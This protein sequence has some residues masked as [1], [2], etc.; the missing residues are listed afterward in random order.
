MKKTIR[1]L[2]CLTLVLTMVMA[3]GITAFAAQDSNSHLN[4]S[5]VNLTDTGTVVLTKY[6]E[7]LG[8]TADY[9][10]PEE[11]YTVTIAKK[12]FE[13]TPSYVTMDNMP[14]I[15]SGSLTFEDDATT[16]AET[17]STDGRLY[18]KV[19]ATLPIPAYQY[20][21][22]YWYTVTENVPTNP[23]AGVTYDAAK[24]YLHVQVIKKDGTQV[25]SADNLI[26]LVTLH[27]QSDED[28]TTWNASKTDG[29]TNKYGSGKLMINKTVQGNQG[30]QNKK[31]EVN[32]T[33]NAP[34]GET[35][36]SIITYTY[37]DEDNNV[38]EEQIEAGWADSKEIAVLVS[39]GETATF[40]NIPYGVTYKVI[41]TDFS[42][43]GYV[44]PTYTL[45]KVSGE[46]AGDV[47]HGTATSTWDDKY[48]T[49]KISDAEDTVKIL[50][51]KD[52]TIDVGVAL[53][54][55]PF[56]MLIA[57]VALGAAA[58]VIA[59]RKKAVR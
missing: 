3:M 17:S 40:T 14:A 51:R 32:V 56:V 18:R 43:K 8:D 39:H 19:T 23:S 54:D 22:D 34:V 25:A 15:N 10:C 35:V 46:E 13:N 57:V 21:G 44:V 50:N 7:I 5:D 48:V 24:Y 45:D 49:G 41:E 30:E 36:T 4:I 16:P 58:Y 6:I 11:D 33:L 9:K 47:V 29:I 59:R 2:L 31:F 28:S 27:N 37:K 20:A 38:V 12:S 42:D 53:D 1:T 26:R 55:A 52:A